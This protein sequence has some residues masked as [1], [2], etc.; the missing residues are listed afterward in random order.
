MLVSERIGPF[1][2]LKR[3]VA[4]IKKTWGEALIAQVGLSGLSLLA[5]I[6][7]FLAFG[8]GGIMFDIA[9]AIGVSIWVAAVI[10]VFLVF[11]A[12][13]TLESILKAA[14]YLYATEG[15]VSTQFDAHLFKHAFVSTPVDD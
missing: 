12:V 8:A 7:G 10:W 2:A 14:L 3:S 6:P 4:I 13:T 1:A 5:I 15:T 11:L 9:P